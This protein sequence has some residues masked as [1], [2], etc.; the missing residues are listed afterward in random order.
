MSESVVRSTPHARLAE[1]WAI[2]L[3]TEGIDARVETRDGA[4][5]IVTTDELHEYAV[6]VLDGLYTEEEDDDEE[7][8]PPPRPVAAPQWG[9]TWAGAI[10]A[11]VLLAFF[12]MRG[13][14]DSAW[15]TAGEAS[16]ARIAAGE[17]WRAITAVTLHADLP[18]VLSNAAATAVFVT[19]LAWRIGP[20]AATA[21]SL[22][23]GALANL[24]VAILHAGGQ[25]SVGASTA[26]FAA[27][28]ALA[29]V[30]ALD[31]GRRRRAWIVLGAALAL[32]GFLGTA[33]GTDLAGHGF[34][35]LFGL[36]LAAP[37]GWK[38]RAPLPA[39][40]QAALAIA[41]VA[42]VTVAWALALR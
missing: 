26:T 21:V 2:A 40:A 8:E 7:E 17:W 38:G 5:V 9:R 34:G 18:H 4:F 20:G 29:A 14:P 10:L 30:S 31:L 12:A 39:R 32:L 6:R 28:G 35:W 15:F 22:A 42:A 19:A 41:S 11:W 3:A 24:V 25:T 37:L 27:L 13:S 16:S 33:P 1:L 23:A 36:L